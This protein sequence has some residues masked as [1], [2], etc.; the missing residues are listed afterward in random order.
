[1][2]AN[3]SKGVNDLNLK[4]HTTQSPLLHQAG[5]ALDKHALDVLWMLLIST[6]QRLA[7]VTCRHALAFTR[8]GRP[9]PSLYKMSTTI[10]LT[11]SSCVAHRHTPSIPMSPSPSAPRAAALQ[12]TDAAPMGPLTLVCRPVPGV[13]PEMLQDPATDMAGVSAA[14]P[15][16]PPALAIV[17]VSPG[18]ESKTERESGSRTHV[19]ELRQRK[20]MHASLCPHV[21]MLKIR[22]NMY[23]R[24]RSEHAMHPDLS[25]QYTSCILI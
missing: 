12:P 25:V 4:Q 2:A 1:V 5:V 6:Q 15:P 8:T 11:H 23:G 9:H 18:S 22:H 10:L 17:G 19:V 7:C 14:R 3:S 13:G 20:H 21:A 24:G 16:E